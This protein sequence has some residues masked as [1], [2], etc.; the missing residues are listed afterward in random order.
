MT[1]IEQLRQE[2]DD[3]RHALKMAREQIRE[4]P[5]PLYEQ[6]SLL[7]YIDKALGPGGLVGTIHEHE[8][9]PLTS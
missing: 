9:L 7:A 4:F 6:E 3:L 5:K 8:G 2:A 1:E